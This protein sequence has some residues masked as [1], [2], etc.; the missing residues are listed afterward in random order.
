MRA[1]VGGEAEGALPGRIF[2]TC[3][4][5]HPALVPSE[6]GTVSSAVWVPSLALWLLWPEHPLG[7]P[8]AW[9][10]SFTAV[11]PGQGSRHPPRGPE[12]CLLHRAG[13]HLSLPCPLLGASL[14]VLN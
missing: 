13:V 2:S 10:V 9:P 8:L 11:T 12:A 3:L 7:S 4:S 1:G 14:P 6:G 5:S